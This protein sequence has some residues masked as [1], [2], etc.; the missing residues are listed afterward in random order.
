[1]KLHDLREAGFDLVGT[2]H[3]LA[4]FTADF[5]K[6]LEELC[7]TL[8]RHEIKCEELVKGGGGESENTQRLRKALTQKG[9]EKRNV[10]IRKT[11]DDRERESS[12]HEIDHFRKHENG[13]IALEIEWNNKDP[14]FDRDLENFQRLH[15]EGVISVGVIVT[16]GS[17]L[18][19]KML[20]MIRRHVTKKRICGYEDLNRLGITTPTARQKRNIEDKINRMIDQKL[21]RNTGTSSEYSF[22]E[23]WSAQFVADKFG[24]ATTHWNKL[25]ARISRGVGNPCPLV[26]IGIP[27]SVV[28]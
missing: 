15:T 6:P 1:M 14:F 8:L 27:A 28:T 18:Q 17:S 20:E 9:W 10:V 16:R 26:L 21:D 22:V 12:T 11:V 7:S 5:P 4:I 3:A 2:N 19:N 23:A 13:A 24:A 25:Q